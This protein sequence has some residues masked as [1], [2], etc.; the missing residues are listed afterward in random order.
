MKRME[1]GGVL[2]AVAASVALAVVVNGLRLFAPRYLPPRSAITKRKTSFAIPR[3]ICGTGATRI[4]TVEAVKAA[5]DASANRRLTCSAVPTTTHR[6]VSYP[7]VRYRTPSRRNYRLPE[8]TL[9][10][11]AAVAVLR[12]VR[13]PNRLLI[14]GTV[15][16]T[17]ARRTTMAV[18]TTRAEKEGDDVAV[19]AGLAVAAS[20]GNDAA[21]AAPG[22]RRSRSPI[23]RYPREVRF[24]PIFP[25]A[26]RKPTRAEKE[27]DDDVSVLA[28]AASGNCAAAAAVAVP[29]RRRVIA[30]RKPIPRRWRRRPTLFPPTFLAATRAEGGGVAV[31]GVAAPGKDAAAAA[32]PVRCRVVAPRPDPIPRRRRRPRILLPS[33]FLAGRTNARRAE[34]G[35]GVAFVLGVAVAASGSAVKSGRCRVAPEKC[36]TRRCRPR[37]PPPPAAA[38]AVR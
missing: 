33:T 36:W 13:L 20:S 38:A 24:K 30:R 25:T 29:G 32:S 8:R 12:C 27:G 7:A 22:R 17:T 11:M 14:N 15:P 34:G 19:L 4:R 18:T 1:E 2:L 9:L 23:P 35:G 5:M 16:T 31:L 28:V 37:R 21:A 3:P 26:R 10:P 6:A